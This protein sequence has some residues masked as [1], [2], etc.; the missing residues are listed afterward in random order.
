MWKNLGDYKVETDLPTPEILRSQVAH[1]SVQ[2]RGK[3]ENFSCI[4]DEKSVSYPKAN[5][6]RM[7][8]SLLLFFSIPEAIFKSASMQIYYIWIFSFST[9]L[10][11]NRYD[12]ISFPVHL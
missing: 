7:R 1:L 6:K 3:S 11:P 4:Y 10:T 9:S 8:K 12:N 2:K 5:W